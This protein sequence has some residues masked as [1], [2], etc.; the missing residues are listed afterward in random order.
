MDDF[1]SPLSY[2]LSPCWHY[3]TF[4]SYS[5]LLTLSSINFLCS[6]SFQEIFMTMSRPLP[7]NDKATSRPLKD[8]S[9]NHL[10]QCKDH[11]KI[12]LRLIQHYF[13]TISMKDLFEATLRLAKDYLQNRLLQCMLKQNIFTL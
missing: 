2:R 6:L 11:F 3:K 5:S 7:G 10:R 8:N 1:Q 12:V 13:K 9:M 4:Y